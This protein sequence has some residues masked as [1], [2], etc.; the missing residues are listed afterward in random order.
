[1]FAYSGTYTVN[2]DRVIAVSESDFHFAGQPVGKVVNEAADTT[3]GKM[4][5]EL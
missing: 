2:S 1:M 3:L 5:A 4:V